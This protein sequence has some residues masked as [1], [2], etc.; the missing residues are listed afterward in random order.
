MFKNIRSKDLNLERSLELLKWPPF[1]CT[2]STVNQFLKYSNSIRSLCQ[3][4]HYHRAT[5][6][7]E[8]PL[9]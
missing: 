9:E 7:R 8:T 1:P 3:C 5:I 2:H 6:R 4:Q